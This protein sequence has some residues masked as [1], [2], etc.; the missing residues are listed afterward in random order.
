[1]K[2]GTA[3]KAGAIVEKL[4]IARIREILA[5]KAKENIDVLIAKDKALEPEAAA[6]ENVEK[7]TRYVR[8]LHKLCINFVNFK[9]LY[10]GNAPAIFQAG[11]LYLDQR[12]CN[13]CLTVDDAARHG[14][15]AGLAGAYLAYCDCVRKGTGEKL[16][17]VAIF[18]QGGD[19]NLMVGRNGV[20]YD[21]KGRDYD[22]TIT[23]IL[24]NPISLRQ[25]FWSPYKKLVRMIEEQVAKR[26]A[27]ADTDVNT[28]MAATA[29]AAAN[30]TPAA[31]ARGLRAETVI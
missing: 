6:I 5:G 29:T 7:L 30:A 18:S 28:Q 14:S 27:A 16:T 1:M 15:M 31:P 9:D 20:F 21:R 8:D 23:K 13:L 17:I 22:A 26:A 4:G 3:A 19:D 24:P 11:T 10:G 2:V 12:S 25:A